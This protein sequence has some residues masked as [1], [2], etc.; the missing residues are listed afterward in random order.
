MEERKDFPMV[1]IKRMFLMIAVF[2]MF[3][4]SGVNLSLPI[5]FAPL[6][7]SLSQA[8]TVDL[9]QTGQKTCYDTSGNVIPC[10]GTGQDGE[11]QAGVPWPSP[12]F[13]DNGNGT[14]TDK[15]TGLMWLKECK[16][17]KH[18]VSSF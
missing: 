11:I 5:S 14:V 10:T 1:A 16:L 13:T 4:V 6:T 18:E 9:P 2:I 8:G 15:L 17:H 7:T 12:R 3:V